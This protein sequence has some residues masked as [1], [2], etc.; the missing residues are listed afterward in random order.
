MLHCPSGCEVY[1]A[2]RRLYSSVRKDCVRHLREKH[3]LNGVGL[4]QAIRVMLGT[5][6][7]ESISFDLEHV[8]DWPEIVMVRVIE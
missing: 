7:R 4:E 5:R 8:P 3:R 2:D 6:F 1:A